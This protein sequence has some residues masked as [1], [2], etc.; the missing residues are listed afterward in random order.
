[1]LALTVNEVEA[2]RESYAQD[3]ANYKYF[4]RPLWLLYENM[5]GAGRLAGKLLQ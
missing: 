2:T 3:K 1:M 4:K 5:A